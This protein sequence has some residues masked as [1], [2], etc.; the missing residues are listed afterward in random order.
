MSSILQQLADYAKVRTQAYKKLVSPGE[1]KEKALS[2][3]KGVEHFL[4]DLHGEYEL[5]YHIFICKL[6]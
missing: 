2:L 5:F 3:P 6:D 4:S 1:M